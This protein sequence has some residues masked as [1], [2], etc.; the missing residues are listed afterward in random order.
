M[1]GPDMVAM[2]E[3]E[4]G[5]LKRLNWKGESF[6]IYSQVFV[7]K[8]KHLSPAIKAFIEMTS[9]GPGGRGQKP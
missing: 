6:P 4:N 7:H 9:D 8:D 1:T 2:N 5:S 3:L